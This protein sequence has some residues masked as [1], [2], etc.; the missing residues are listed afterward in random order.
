ME[1]ILTDRY[2]PGELSYESMSAFQQLF[3]PQPDVQEVHQV[4]GEGN[5]YTAYQYTWLGGTTFD[6]HSLFISIDSM[7]RLRLQRYLAPIANAPRRLR[8]CTLRR[9]QAMAAK[10]RRHLKRRLVS[11]KRSLDYAGEV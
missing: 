10:G 7:S 6:P 3:M 1:K 5:P 4:D 8:K 9:M 11:E 2:K